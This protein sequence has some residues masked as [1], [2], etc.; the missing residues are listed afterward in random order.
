MANYCELVPVRYRTG[1]SATENIKQIGISQL[2][3]KFV[4]VIDFAIHLS[5]WF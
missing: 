1:A 5:I 2:L 4:T 3:F